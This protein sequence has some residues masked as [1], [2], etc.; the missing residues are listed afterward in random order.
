MSELEKLIE[1]QR[2]DQRLGNFQPRETFVALSLDHSLGN[3]G[4]TWHDAFDQ[5]G[6][7]V[8]HPG[9]H[10]RRAVPE[11]P[12][13]GYLYSHL[14]KNG[15]YRC[16]ECDRLRSEHRRRAAGIAPR[17][18]GPQCGHDP[19]QFFLVGSLGVTRCRQCV[20]RRHREFYYR[21]KAARAAI[22]NVPTSREGV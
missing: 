20:N 14:D 6:Q 3:L 15:Q 11:C 5:D 19:E 22:P 8:I 2:K 7:Q 17:A 4:G 9:G 18:H 1:E 16:R 12:V 10:E 13:H 21:K